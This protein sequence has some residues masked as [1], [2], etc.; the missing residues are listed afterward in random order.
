MYQMLKSHGIRQALTQE[1]PAA[2]VAMLAAETLYKFHSFT[3]ECLAFLIT[4][5]IMSFGLAQFH[6]RKKALSSRG[7]CVI[8]SPPAPKSVGPESP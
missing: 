1:L 8:S 5:A 7:A 6:T 2:A 4:W 3:L